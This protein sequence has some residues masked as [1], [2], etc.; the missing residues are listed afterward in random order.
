MVLLSGT[1]NSIENEQNKLSSSF[2]NNFKNNTLNSFKSITGVN[3]K[4][5]PFN[6]NQK[7][8]KEEKLFLENKEKKIIKIIKLLNHKESYLS[9]LKKL[10]F[11]YINLF[12]IFIFKLI[13]GQYIPYMKLPK[14]RRQLTG[15]HKYGIYMPEIDKIIGKAIIYGCDNEVQNLWDDY[16]GYIAENSMLFYKDSEFD[17]RDIEFRKKII[18]SFKPENLSFDEFISNL[19]KERVY[20]LWGEEPP[21]YYNREKLIEDFRKIN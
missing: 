17:R 21:F 16:K 3:N 8:E 13:Y 19:N 5:N 4:M 1:I 15:I 10:L 18:M 6:Y 9:K 11:F 14:L 12:R 2:S 20:F 7:D